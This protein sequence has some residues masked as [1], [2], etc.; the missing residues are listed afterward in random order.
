MC[1]TLLVAD[2]GSGVS[3]VLDPRKYLFVNVDLTVVLTRDPAGDWVHL[4]SV[5]SRPSA[6]R[7]PAWPRPCC[8]TRPA[9]AAGPCRPCWSPRAE[10]SAAARGQVG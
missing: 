9:R 2:S 6:T 8:R 10:P 4:D 5:W 1:R 7:G 3:A